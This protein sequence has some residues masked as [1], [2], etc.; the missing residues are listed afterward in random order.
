MFD[1]AIRFVLREIATLDPPP[2]RPADFDGRV[3]RALERLE[4]TLQLPIDA[5]SARARLS[6]NTPVAYFCAEFGIDS[7]L[8]IYTGGLGVLAADHLKAASD[9]GVPLIAVGLFYHRGYL[10]QRIGRDGEQIV[11]PALNDPRAHGIELLTGPGGQLQNPAYLP[12]LVAA[13]TGRYVEQ[14]LTQ[15]AS[16]LRL[17]LT[18]GN[19]VPGWNVGNPLRAGWT[20]TRGQSRRVAFTNRYGAL[21]RGT[22][23]RPLPGATDPYTGRKLTGPFPGVVRAVLVDLNG[24]GFR[25]LLLAF[26]VAGQP[27][28]RAFDGR[29]LQAL[30]V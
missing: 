22:V 15:V 19:L 23:W 9:L 12:A 24:D 29:T 10:H 3:E 1:Q 16:P 8:Q 11:S 2:E 30:P 6:R 25:D 14:L 20:D 26:V 4:A 27:R 21:L 18:A 13:T 28:L 7:S 17:S 5:V